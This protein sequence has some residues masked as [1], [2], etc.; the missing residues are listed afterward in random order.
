M[1]LGLLQ[2]YC[3]GC[4]FSTASEH[5]RPLPQICP[6]QNGGLCQEDESGNGLICVCLPE[7]SGQHCE[8][9]SERMFGSSPGSAAAIYIPI[10]VAI[11]IAATVGLYFII[12]KRPL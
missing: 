12:K 3:H 10:L 6:C 5:A 8:F 4:F 2:K 11:L 1:G 9:Y 7:F